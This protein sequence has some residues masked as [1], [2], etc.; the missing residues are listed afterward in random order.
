MN[1]LSKWWCNDNKL[2][3]TDYE[4]ANQYCDKSSGCY[5]SSYWKYMEN[6][7]KERIP[8]GFS[9]DNHSLYVEETATSLITSLFDKYIN[10]ET[11][12]ITSMVE[13]E[14]VRLNVSKHN[15]EI[16]DHIVLKFTDNIRNPNLSQIKQAVKSGKYKRA[17]VYIIGTQ[18]TTGEVTPQALYVKIR[19]YL[20][21]V[22]IE[23]IMVIDDVHGMYLVP[24]DYSIFNYVICTAHAL[25]R[26][27]DMGMM[28]SKT[29][30]DFGVKNCGWLSEYINSLDYVLDRK[31]KLATFSEIMKEE[32]NQYL[33]YDYIQYIPD[34]VPHIFSLRIKCVPS[35]VYN[36]KMQKEYEENEVRLETDNNNMFYIR[37]R[38]QQ[39]I[40]FP[41]LFESALNKV[42]DLLNRIILYKESCN[43]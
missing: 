2:S 28:W 11:L 6:S 5:N 39:F 21:S 24:R 14:A 1:N 12:L 7:L 32:F 25:V 35:A 27:Y 16:K 17:F 26:H 33:D 8:L 43:D 36:D 20:L 22:G 34:S 15:R 10:E 19:D 38:G 9:L 42:H 41:E 13:H 4:I 23:P 31:Y 30:E 40:T 29:E 18:I 3:G 37:L